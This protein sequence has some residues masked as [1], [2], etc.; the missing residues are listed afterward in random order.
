MTRTMTKEEEKAAKEATEKEQQ[1][2]NEQSKSEEVTE[3]TTATATDKKERT[4]VTW[5]GEKITF[6]LVGAKDSKKV[7]TLNCSELPAEIYQPCQA[8]RH[9]IEQKLRDTLATDKA[10]AAITTAGEKEKKLNDL[11]QQIKIEGWNKRAVSKEEKV[12]VSVL[13]TMFD[14]MTTEMQELF[15]SKADDGMKR[16]L[17]K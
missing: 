16:M 9:G 13:K 4:K 6:H 5:E 12:S 15:L 1:G 14:G 2:K 8:S 11:F 17:G 3:V 7:L 10:T